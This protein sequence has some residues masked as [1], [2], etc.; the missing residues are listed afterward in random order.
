MLAGDGTQ[1]EQPGFSSIE[2]GGIVDQRFGS[3]G[4]PV[5]RFARFHQRAVERG[6]RFGKQRVLGRDPV[7][8]PGR[9][10]QRRQRRIRFFPDVAKFFEVA[11]QLLAL[12]HR[13]TGF[14]EPRLFARLRFEHCQ[15]GQVRQQ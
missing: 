8:P 2:F 6:E 11:R 7:K 3:H 5:F 12:L 9:D 4:Q 14:G 13:S 10:A 15:F 1:F